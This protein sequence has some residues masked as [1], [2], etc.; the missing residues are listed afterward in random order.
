M[1]VRMVRSSERSGTMRLTISELAKATGLT[2]RTLRFYDEIGLVNP[3][4]TTP[5][6]MRYYGP[7]EV[8]RL[9]R[10]LVYRQLQVP[11]EQ[12]GR[13]LADEVDPRAALEQQRVALL[14]EQARVADVLASVDRALRFLTKEG[15]T[16]TAHDAGDLFT[17]FDT[18]AIDSEAQKRWTAEAEQSRDA[19]SGMSDTAKKQA[20]ADHEDRLRRLGALAD[21]GTSPSDPRTLAVVQEMHTAMSSMWTPDR[22]AFEQVGKQLATQPESRVVLE[23]VSAK[24]PG[25]LPEAYAAFAAAHLS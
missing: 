3:A 16:M 1:T 25:F 9:Q 21:D 19:I 6:G 11:L 10:V 15:T 8:L 23:R 20:Q 22:A 13:I 2:A 12:I 5:A 18:T 17:G 7:D 4:G 14:G 24:L